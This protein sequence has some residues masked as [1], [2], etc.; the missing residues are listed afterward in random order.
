MGTCAERLVAV[1]ARSSRSP[2]VSTTCSAVRTR[3]FPNAA[4]ISPQAVSATNA[5][6]SPGLSIS[7]DR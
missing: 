6:M 7:S 5:A 4:A 2:R 3:R 1:R